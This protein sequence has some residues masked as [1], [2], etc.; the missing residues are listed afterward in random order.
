MKRWEAPDSIF[1]PIVAAVPA[2]TSWAGFANALF[3][4]E[5][6]I[7]VAAVLYKVKRPGRFKREDEIRERMSV[8]YSGDRA[9]PFTARARLLDRPRGAAAP[10]DA[11]ATLWEVGLTHLKDGLLTPAVPEDWDSAI[12]Q[13]S[14]FRLMQSGLTGAP[15]LALL[16]H[17][18]A[19][20]VLAASPDA[21]VFGGQRHWQDEWWN[22]R[23]AETVE[24]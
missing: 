13:T 9:K 4:A 8:S 22:E 11:S 23:I 16:R 18:W 15:Q 10:S 21:I 5:E 2:R 19:E 20:A 1:A 7:P 17:R 24:V 3:A 14:T 12:L 6:G